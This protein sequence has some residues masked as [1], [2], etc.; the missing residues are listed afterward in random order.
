MAYIQSSLFI[1]S[2]QEEAFKLFV[3]ELQINLLKS[4][5]QFEEEING[6]IRKGNEILGKILTFDQGK[7]IRIEWISPN[8]ERDENLI[9]EILFETH[10]SGTLV[11]FEPKSLVNHFD[12]Q[13]SEL[14]GWFVDTLIIDIFSNIEPEIFGDWKTDRSARRPIGINA[15]KVYGNPLYH[16]PNFYFLLEKMSL[17]SLDYILE[18]GC[19]G[20]VLLGEVLK[21][22][23]KAVGIDHSP[24][25]I[26]LARANNLVSIENSKLEVILGDASSIPFHDITFSVVVMTGVFQFITN[27]DIVLQDILRVLKPSGRLFIF[28]V[29]KEMKGTIAAPEPVASRMRFYDKTELTE[30]ISEK[31]F[32]K[33]EVEQADLLPYAKRVGIPET[34]LFLFDRKYSLLVKAEK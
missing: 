9:I 18:L 3:N 10:K 32:S 7:I 15:R 19:G 20:G 14:A 2:N 6:M 27:P 30:L 13:E 11:T 12:N 28:L 21:S 8:P 29:S 24:E 22:G 16:W 31:G 1:N 17:T 26:S 25:M 23:C 5:V 33:V 4:G 34:D